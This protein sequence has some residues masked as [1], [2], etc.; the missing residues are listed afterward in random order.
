MAFRI[1]TNISSITTQGDLREST[2]QLARTQ[3]KLSSGFRIN[4]AADDAAG[5][6]VSESMYAKIRSHIQAKRNALDAVS[7]IQIAESS[8]NEM[9]SLLIRIRELAIQSASDTI[10]DKERM[11]ANKEYKQLVSEIDRIGNTTEF[12]GIKLFR[13]GGKTQPVEH[14]T[15]HIGVGSGKQPNQDTLELDLNKLE[16]YAQDTLHLTVEDGLGPEDNSERPYGRERSATKLDLVDS[17]LDK[18][19]SVRAHLGAKQNRLDS[20]IRN[21]GIAEEN[22][23]AAR[24][25]IRDTN[26]ARESAAYTQQ[27]ILQESGASILSQ[28]NA[29][30]ELAISL[31]R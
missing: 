29:L 20:S 28:A 1:R 4:R 19:N 11:L 24:S 31:L 21:L 16:I 9:G 18:I 17:A 30:P 12:N 14:M 13:K 7:A 6:A 25:R 26:F 10:G 2:A 27:R 8:M 22:L 5:L 23:S 15:L 3:T